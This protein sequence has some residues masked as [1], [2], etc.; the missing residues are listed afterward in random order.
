MWKEYN[1][2]VYKDCTWCEQWELCES[3]EGC[4]RALTV[5]VKEAAKKANLPIMSYLG[6]PDCYKQKEQEKKK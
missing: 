1:L 6:N 4:T 2:L 5:D 3:G